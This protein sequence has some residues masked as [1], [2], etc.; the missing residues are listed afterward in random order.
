M[1]SLRRAIGL[2]RAG[3]RGNRAALAAAAI[4]SIAASALAAP[5]AAQTITEGSGDEPVDGPGVMV[6]D[7]FA[8]TTLDWCG[9]GEFVDY[10]EGKPGGG[11]NDDYIRIADNCAD[12]YSIRAQVWVDDV[13]QGVRINDNGYWGEDVIWDPF[14]NV[15]PGQVVELEIC[16]TDSSGGHYECAEQGDV[17]TDG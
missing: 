2:P 14:P 11:K 4:A 15:K 5:A 13:S 6:D 8:V 12:G 7:S 3:D 17:S 9:Y 16:L 1:L 10:G